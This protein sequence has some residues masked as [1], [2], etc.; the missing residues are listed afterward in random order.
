[1]LHALLNILFPKVCS[2]CNTTLSSLENTICI[3]CRH[4]LPLANYHKV[5]NTL[6][7]DIFYGRIHVEQATAL[8]KF[9]KKGITQELLHNLKYR[10]QEAI[11]SFFGKWLGAELAEISS[12]QAIDLVIPVPLHKIKKRKRG[13]NQVTGFG[14]EIAKALKRPYVA[15]VLLKAVHTESQVFKNRL[16]R[17]QDDTIFYI[18]N[19]DLI[20]NKH[21]LLVDDIITTGAT[22]ENCALQLQKAAKCKISFATIA[23][24]TS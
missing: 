12:Y 14:T 6:M 18:D 3:S 2:A 20:K 22:L 17:F 24:T 19:P 5:D 10:N 21:I 16:K 15:N 4:A 13:Y 7:R 11:S 9:Q 8:L 1:M 23:I